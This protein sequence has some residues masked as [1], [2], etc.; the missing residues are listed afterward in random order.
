MAAEI[1][2]DNITSRT[3]ELVF[4]SGPSSAEAV[5]ITSTGNVGI[6]ITNA[7]Y[8]LH[9]VGSGTTA[10][11]VDGQAQLTK[12]AITTTSSNITLEAGRTYAYYVGVTTLT[13]PASPAAGDTV[14]VIN[15]SGV[16]TATIA[17]NGSNI[18]GTAD[19]LTFDLINDSYRFTYVNSTDGWVIGR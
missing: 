15:R 1:R 14:V 17:R 19:D 10:L 11:Y 6:G 8:E 7:N 5:R 4:S 9:V 3:N 13:L 12:V 18:V 2:V 16:D